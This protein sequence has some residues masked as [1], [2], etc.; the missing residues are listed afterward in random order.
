M[1]IF[2]VIG[3][4]KSQRFPL[5]YKKLTEPRGKLLTASN[6]LML[7]KVLFIASE[8]TRRSRTQGAAEKV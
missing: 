1:S 4:G 6:L 3:C 5:T 8:E 2:C 7:L